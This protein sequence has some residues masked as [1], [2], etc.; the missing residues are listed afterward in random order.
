MMT[1]QLA[2]VRFPPPPPI[3]PWTELVTHGQIL[4][5]T[6]HLPDNRPVP[7]K[8]PN[9]ATGQVR[10]RTC[11]LPDRIGTQHLHNAPPACTRVWM[12]FPLIFC[13]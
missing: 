2:G 7:N 3:L 13:S 11:H 10:D 12:V 5:R 4:D 8:T 9:Q 1:S 6:R